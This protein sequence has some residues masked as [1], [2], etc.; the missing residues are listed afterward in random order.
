[1]L[2][3]LI[4]SIV[5]EGR[6]RRQEI[7]ERLANKL[8]VLV[9]LPLLLLARLQRNLA[10]GLG[11]LGVGERLC[12]TVVRLGLLQVFV[13][14]RLLVFVVLLSDV[15]HL[16]TDLVKLGQGGSLVDL[17]FV[18]QRLGALE[19]FADLGDI[20]ALVFVLKVLNFL[21]L[22]LR[23]ILQFLVLSGQP[24]QIGLILIRLTL[25]F[26][27]LLVKVLETVLHRRNLR[28]SLVQCA[29]EIRNLAFRLLFELVEFLLHL[30]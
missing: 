7:H 24:F 4:D 12:R 11:Q 17:R 25:L 21:L 23:L 9:A 16:V 30:T 15:E 1:M 29:I 22:T 5:C 27:Q 13:D 26:I 10:L 19:L 28:I 3:V 6:W 18:Q 20:N 14:L 8:D 2:F